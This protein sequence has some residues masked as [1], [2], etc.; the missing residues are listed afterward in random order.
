ME[1]Q[2]PFGA[3]KGGAPRRAELPNPE[4]LGPEGG[5]KVERVGRAKISRFFLLS[6]HHFALFC[7]S[8]GVFSLNFGCLK[9]RGRSPGGPEAREP[10]RAH[11]R[12][13]AFRNIGWSG[14]QQRQQQHNN[15]TQQPTVGLPKSVSAHY[16]EITFETLHLQDAC[17]ENES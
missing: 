16:E 13:A 15:N 3:P 5:S 12:V 11:I 2:T 7:V 1:E 4:K 9:R 8:L 17:G 14:G 10:K 6:R